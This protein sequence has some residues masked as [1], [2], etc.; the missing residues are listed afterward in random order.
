MLVEILYVIGDRNPTNPMAPPD[1]TPITWQPAG[2]K[3]GKMDRKLFG[4]LLT[5]AT[6]EELARLM[7][8]GET[9]PD[10][11]NGLGYPLSRI[12]YRRELIGID[13]ERA[14]DASRSTPT[15]VAP[16][17][18]DMASIVRS[19]DPVAAVVTPLAKPEPL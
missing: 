13:L 2:H 7:H 9:D 17:L 18:A 15:I 6:E 11:S 19:W 4:V 8:D 14:Q 5:S 12:D 1:G 10:E 3:W 16:R